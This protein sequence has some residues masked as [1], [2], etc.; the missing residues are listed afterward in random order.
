MAA[1]VNPAVVS[2][3]VASITCYKKAA[4]GFDR[5]KGPVTEDVVSEVNAKL[6]QAAKVLNQGLTAIS[7]LNDGPI[8]PHQQILLDLQG[9]RQAIDALRK[10]VPD[11]KAALTALAGVGESA[12]SIQV[13]FGVR[14]E[15]YCWTCPRALEMFAAVRETDS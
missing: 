9:M 8:Y 5:R 15:H 12:T 3:V 10:D 7:P 1:G 11:K 4:A 14:Y 6:L 13:S 2:N